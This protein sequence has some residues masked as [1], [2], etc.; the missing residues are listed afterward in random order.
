MQ[1]SHGIRTTVLRTVSLTA[2]LLLTA[3][4]GSNTTDDTPPPGNNLPVAKAGADQTVNE[5]VAVTL[6]GSASSDADND[7]L[8]YAWMQTDGP[9]ITLTDS[10]KAIATFN[11]PEVSGQTVVIFELTVTDGSTTATDSVSITVTDTDVPAANT[12]PVAAAGADQSVNDGATVTLDGS[13]SSDADNDV[14][15]FS[16]TQT[17]GP[18]VA[19]ADAD[20][21]SAKFTAPTIPGGTNLSF[22]LTVNDGLATTKDTVTVTVNDITKPTAAMTPTDGDILGK[23]QSIT[24]VFNEPMNTASLNLTGSLASEAQFSWADDD[25]T[26]TVSPKI[27]TKWTSGANRML[28]VSA[29]DVAGNTADAVDGSYLVRLVFSIFQSADV[30]IG[31]PDMVSKAPALAADRVT[32]PSG[33]AILLNGK[34]YVPDTMGNRILGFNQLPGADGSAAD[35]VIGQADFI[36]KTA[37]TSDSEISRPRGL[38]QHDNTLIVADSG[39][40]RIGIYT[41]APTADQNSGPGAMNVVVGQAN[42]ASADPGC[43]ATGLTGPEDVI[44]TPDGKLIVADTSNN[45]VL[46]WNSLPAGSGIPADMVLGQTGFATCA[47]NDADGD[48]VSD[49]PSASSMYGPKNVWS[50]GEKLVVLDENNHRALIW[51]SFPTT[52]GQAA[53]LVLGQAAFENNSP[54]DSDGD[55]LIDNAAAN[56]MNFPGGG[57]ASNGVQLFIGDRG[58]NRLLIW[59]SW[60][61]VNQQ[62]ADD[63]IGQSDLSLTARNDDDAD[64]VSDSNPTARTLFSP[65]GVY[66]DDD[67]LIVTDKGNN[68]FLIYTSK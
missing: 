46:I 57:V 37:G 9:E 31:Q 24:V 58:G 1:S 40:N 44:V 26:L 25:K 5:G 8:T 22:E 6:D 65:E 10:N 33:R 19:V 66:L 64:G 45:R 11:A 14:L 13:A 16:W 62:P 52:S 3:C 59:N 34:T 4:G 63:V 30:V 29:G 60:P 17:A 39:N 67:K 53:D 51:N 49:D 55:N 15:T 41:L 32:T 21:A 2:L 68:R 27:G 7:S 35:F 38:W 23:S 28:S 36:S 43:S 50:D 20:K 47:D 12:V 61:T 18:N 54:L 56:T 42:F 48:N